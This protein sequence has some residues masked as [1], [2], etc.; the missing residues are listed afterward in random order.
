MNFVYWV[1]VHGIADDAFK[2]I[3]SV[4]ELLAQRPPEG[5][6]SWTLQWT[7][8]AKDLPFFR[9]VTPSGP[10]SDKGLTF[11]SLRHHFTSLRERDGFQNQLRVHGIR[12]QVA[13]RVDRMLK[14]R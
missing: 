13:N 11:S 2:G 5:R 9:M 6:E 7:D 1:M 4:D 12:G 14:L 10:R 8:T 3:S